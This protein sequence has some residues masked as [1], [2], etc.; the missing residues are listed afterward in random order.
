VWSST[1]A[2]NVIEQIVKFATPEESGR[3]DFVNNPRDCLKERGVVKAA[4]CD[5]VEAQ[6]VGADLNDSARDRESELTRID[7]GST[8]CRV[9]EVWVR[10]TH[11]S[12]FFH[13]GREIAV[14]T[15]LTLT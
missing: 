1:L 7:P 8:R 6:T 5:D 14:E 15:R 9:F 13:L 11:D 12:A 4:C 3:C 10:S 2:E